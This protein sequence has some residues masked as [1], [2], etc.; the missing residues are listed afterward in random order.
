MTNLVTNGIKITVQTKYN[1]GYSKPHSLYHLFNYHIQIENLSDYTVQLMRRHWYI[2]DSIGQ[3]TE[4]EGEGVV[5]Q[6]PLLSPNENYAYSSACNLHSDMGKMYGTY[7]F[8][9]KLDN[10]L[11]E[12][13]IPEFHL[14]V[15]FRLN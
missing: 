10:K 7:T 1:E 3:T 6:Q 8:E 13:K 11:F 9:R 12:V 15:P 4:V 2:I 5:G 14:V